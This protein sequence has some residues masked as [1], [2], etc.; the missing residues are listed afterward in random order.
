MAEN[1][2]I[3]IGII[4]PIKDKTMPKGCGKPKPKK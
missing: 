4:H 3:S 1:Y 2:G